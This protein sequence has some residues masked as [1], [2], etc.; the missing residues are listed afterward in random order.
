MGRDGAAAAHR[1]PLATATRRDAMARPTDR[2][3]PTASGKLPEPPHLERSR[4]RRRR[5]SPGEAGRPRPRF[6][7]AAAAAAP[8]LPRAPP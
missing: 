1:E 8:L 2:R 5:R 4:R 6:Y 3:A 7:T